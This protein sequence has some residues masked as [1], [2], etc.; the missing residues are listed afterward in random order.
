MNGRHLSPSMLKAATLACAALLGAGAI[1][2]SGGCQRRMN[3]GPDAVIGP[4]PADEAMLRREW[5]E[6]HA[7]YANTS[8]VAGNTGFMDLPRWDL[9]AWT[10]PFVD[11]S[12][13]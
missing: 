10:Y 3:A 13:F 2:T 11:N 1:F 6:S 8:V 7:I 5:Q 12:V 9:P 4:P